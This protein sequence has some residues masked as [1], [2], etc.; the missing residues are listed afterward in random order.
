MAP[1]DADIANAVGVHLMGFLLYGTPFRTPVVDVDVGVTVPAHKAASNE[2]VAGFLTSDDVGD[3]VLKV[4][5]RVRRDGRRTGLLFD[6]TL[7]V[8]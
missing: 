1:D 8:G 2:P 5:D 6:M 3:G 4:S 7:A